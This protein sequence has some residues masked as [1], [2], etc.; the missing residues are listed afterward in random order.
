M[1]NR[2]NSESDSDSVYD[3]PGEM[4]VV[5][6][7]VRDTLEG[8]SKNQNRA[9][10]S[11]RAYV[12]FDESNFQGVRDY[13]THMD[14]HPLRYFGEGEH[15]YP[16]ERSRVLPTVQDLP[17][18]IPTNHYS[19]MLHEPYYTSSQ[20]RAR[21]P[22]RMDYAQG[23]PRNPSGRFSG[24]SVN[25]HETLGG[26][27]DPISQLSDHHDGRKTQGGFYIPYEDC[28]T[29]AGHYDRAYEQFTSPPR[30]GYVRSPRVR[31]PRENYAQPSEYVRPTR[32]S[33]KYD[34]FD[35][36]RRVHNSP[37]RR[38]T[39]TRP[40]VHT[41]PA[42]RD[43]D[44]RSIGENHRPASFQKNPTPSSQMG[45]IGMSKDH[46][47]GYTD[48]SH[49]ADVSPARTGFLS[50]TPEY[51]RSLSF[52]S[53]QS[54]GRQFKKCPSYDGTSSF[55]DFLIQFEMISEFNNW[56]IEVM[57]QEL[58]LSLKGQ[59]VAVLADLDSAHRRY[60]P[61]L[62]EALK[63][64]FEPDNQIQ[65][66]RAKLKS[67]IRKENEPLPQLAQDIRRLVR[68]ANPGVPLDIRE[69]MAKDS[70]LDALNDKELELSVFQSQ[71]RNLQDALR[72]ALEIEAFY[73]SRE[74]KV[75]LRLVKH[76]MESSPPANELIES[77]QAKIAKLE[78][79][80]KATQLSKNEKDGLSQVSIATKPKANK[81]NLVCYYCDKPG[82]IAR[83]CQKRLADRKRKRGDTLNVQKLE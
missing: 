79:E 34:N 10:E 13:Q 1:S 44:G 40:R 71:P 36:E 73:R 43:A 53:D 67:R 12:H 14:G 41:S 24:Q 82:H 75:P 59:A 20:Y 83:N 27:H 72:I 74:R 11:G 49:E 55:K 5:T 23:G 17:K 66:H 78:E 32:E 64:R 15:T 81:Y 25:H 6:D 63:A 16:K 3:V 50:R 31:S 58:A 45:Y 22:S 54:H 35:R 4:W 7:S 77:L 2:S 26:S 37:S 21:S 30:L 61:S 65:L 52:P 80:L 38:D 69:T 42:R 8:R 39:Y 28:R 51:N 62:V 47:P 33:Y 68:D 46:F 19:D 18:Q 76:D 48:R 9:R 29:P 57:A 60:Y 70:F 56:S